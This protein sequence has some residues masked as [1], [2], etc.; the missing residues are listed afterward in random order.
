MEVLPLDMK[1]SIR[2]CGNGG[3]F[4][5]TGLYRSRALGRYRAFVN[6]LNR[7]VV[8]RFANRTAVVSPDDPHVFAEAVRCIAF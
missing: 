7:T 1:G 5:F 4:S 3:I 6:D 8:L 2:L